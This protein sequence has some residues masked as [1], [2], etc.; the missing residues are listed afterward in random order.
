MQTRRNLILIAMLALI[1]TV[2]ATVVR[3]FLPSELDDLE[4][5]LDASVSESL[6]LDGA[7]VE[8]WD[9]LSGN[10]RHVAQS[11]ASDRPLYVSDG[12]NGLPALEFSGSEF[13][14]STAP[15]SDWIFM[16][17]S[18][19]TV[20][21][22]VRTEKS[23]DRIGFLGTT[24][25]TSSG[26][27]YQLQYRDDEND[28]LDLIVRQLSTTAY[29][30]ESGLGDAKA[31]LVVLSDPKNATVADRSVFHV[32]G[33]AGAKANTAG[34]TVSGSSSAPSYT[35]HVG[36]I[37][38]AVFLFEGEIAELLIYAALLSDDDREKVEGYLAHKWI[39]ADELPET[40]PFKSSPPGEADFLPAL[41]F[42]LADQQTGS[43]D[44]TNSNEV[45]LVDFPIPEGCDRFQF[46]ES[47]EIDAID[48]EG[49]EPTNAVPARVPFTQ[50]GADTN[51]TLYA[52][53]TNS[54]ESVALRRAE[55]SIVYTTVA[56]VPV[57]RNAHT[58][59]R[60]P[61]QSVTVHPVEI[62]EGSTGGET[63]GLPMG[64]HSLSLTLVEGPDTDATPDE[65][66]VTVSEL[67]EYRLLLS[68]VNE[69]GNTAVSS[70]TNVLTVAEFGGQCTWTG[71]GDG[72]DWHDPWNWDPFGVPVDGVPVIIDNGASVRLTNS[73]AALSALMI[74][75][76]TLTMANW[77][78]VL[79]ADTVNGLLSANG[80]NASTSGPRHTAG[81]AGG[82][83]YLSC[84]TFAGQGG[85]VRANGGDKAT[86]HSGGG[87][88]GR[89][90]LHYDAA[91]QALEPLPSVTFSA[92]PG[93]NYRYRHMVWYWNWCRRGTGTGFSE[94]AQWG[95]L[96]FTDPTGVIGLGTGD[97]VEKI[98]G[99]LRFGEGVA[100][101]DG[102]LEF[103]VDNLT[104]ANGATL[105]FDTNSAITITGDLEIA[106]GSGLIARHPLSVAVG[107]ELRLKGKLR[108]DRE[109]A[110]DIGG[111]LRIDGGRLR[112]RKPDVAVGGVLAL[113][114]DGWLVTQ[115]LEDGAGGQVVVAGDISLATNCWIYP[116]SHQT[117][118]GA[119]RF[120]CREMYVAEGAG[121]DAGGAGYSADEAGPGGG[122]RYAS[123]SA[124]QGA[125]GGG[126]G[127]RGGDGLMRDGG[128]AYPANYNARYI[129]QAHPG[130]AGGRSFQV[131]QAGGG[132]A[133]WIETDGS[134][135]LDGI[136]RANGHAGRAA[137]GRRPGSGSGGGIL[138]M[139]E[140]LYGGPQSLIEALGG[141][142]SYSSA[143]AYGG[144]GGGGRIAIW[145]GLK[146]AERQLVFDRI[147]EDAMQYRIHAMESLPLYAG[148]PITA[149]AGEETRPPS[150]DDRVD[151]QDGTVAF[152]RILS[153]PGSLI[154]VR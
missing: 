128:D 153:P 105:G 13:L 54:T 76:A 31:L 144:A 66:W 129:L 42:T 48:T 112:V 35:L 37:G 86:N 7:A 12:F 145:Y 131:E 95:S 38:D 89:I 52:W 140:R 152:L 130:S 16:H 78:T 71:D 82:S 93:D 40:H 137:G 50:P 19:S 113:L 64:V 25:N 74:E 102:T 125:G 116:V 49:W 58:R 73:T 127:G 150:E 108:A 91:A 133:I 81:G 1:L 83:I 99:F 111:D 46:T 45:D 126:Y 84:E 59:E 23:N 6:T 136:L 92:A 67:G 22:V 36:S 29:H 96:Y 149:L 79:T 30:E 18:T 9:D 134:F 24:Q 4:L 117:A 106:P 55:G 135:H 44:F 110:L 15:A 142:Q 26:R 56:P 98:S 5:W 34:G 122:T 75:N 124:N 20:F 114:N 119:T 62:D 47:G 69:A 143:T 63:L 72:N 65:P 88:G 61:G 100:F 57:I 33:G 28:R 139:T 146:A 87:G 118:G 103:A 97:T 14:V 101:E 115:T 17:D 10:I 77:E 104:V 60:L 41:P 39:L 2:T 94:E 120:V 148:A 107:G 85:I 138:V 11:T 154:Q 147:D 21:M 109:T 121:F 90:A 80:A 3:A 68:V 132:G 151:A 43:T 27:G 53:F 70:E 32:N 8:Q 141:N 123:T 51:I